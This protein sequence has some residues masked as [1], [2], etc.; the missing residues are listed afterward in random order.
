LYDAAVNSHEGSPG[1]DDLSEVVAALDYVLENG[2]QLPKSYL[3]WKAIK[4]P[5]HKLHTHHQGD[6]YVGNTA[7]GT[8]NN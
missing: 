6:I 1:C 2:S 5:G 7:F 4:Q 3:F 8:S